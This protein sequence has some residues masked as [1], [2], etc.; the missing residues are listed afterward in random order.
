MTLNFRSRSFRA[1]VPVNLGA[2]QHSWISLFIVTPKTGLKKLRDLI[3]W[4]F[5]LKSCSSDPA[6]ASTP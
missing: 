5:E 6:V 3:K 4:F 2:M 1:S